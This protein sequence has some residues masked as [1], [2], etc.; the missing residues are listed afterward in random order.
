MLFVLYNALFNL[1]V[2]GVADVLMNFYFVSLGH[3]AAAI[4]LLQSVPRVGGLLTSVPVGLLADRLGT[5]RVMIWS[6][7]AIGLCYLLMVAVPSLAVLVLAQFCAGLFFGAQ[8]IALGPFMMR[9]V[10]RHQRIRF[11]ARQN[12]I[13]TIAMTIGIML[14]GVLPSLVVMLNRLVSAAP[15]ADAG[16]QT[17][18]AYGGA[19]LVAGAITLISIV[20][21]LFVRAGYPVKHTPS[22]DA[23]HPARERIPW[24]RL[25]FL[26]LP[27]LPFGFSGGL[28]FPFF[29]LFFR[30]RFG[31]GD[32]LIGVVMAMGWFGMALVPLLN[33]LLERRFGRVNALTLAMMIASVAFVALALAPALWISVIAFAVALSFR[34]IMNPLFPPMLMDTMPDRMHNHVSSLMQIMWSIG[35]FMATSIS[36]ALQMR[37]GYTFT[38]MAAAVTMVVTAL[39]IVLILRRRIPV[40][41]PALAEAPAVGD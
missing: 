6:S 14:G 19:L 28:T 38:T 13:S 16:T 31:A 9:L 15:A 32:E 24:L 37:Y 12:M 18:F 5:R 41:V 1:S 17:P 40:A 36:G 21:L 33:P 3:D 20:P 25:A 34:N 23:P 10:D 29:N 26:S 2:L 35:W 30:E 27:Y 7:L 39:S 8:Q 11:F 22:A 4:A